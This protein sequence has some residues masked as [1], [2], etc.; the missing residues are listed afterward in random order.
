MGSGKSIQAS[1]VIDKVREYCDTSTGEHLAFAYFYFDFNNDDYRDPI[2]MLRSLLVQVGTMN[3]KVEKSLKQRLAVP[4]G[5]K[6]QPSIEL[7][8]SCLRELVQKFGTSYIVLDALDECKDWYE[9]HRMITRILSWGKTLKVLLISRKERDIEE[10]LDFL[11]AEKCS[12]S[13]QGDGVDNDMRTYIQSMWNMEL[14]AWA[15]RLEK[16]PKRR[17]EIEEELVTKA[18]GM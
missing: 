4:W 12:I 17:M 18:D 8:Y 11:Q 13:L 3:P 2:K 10:D 9:L 5:E 6:R 14:R 15:R 16:R 1:R 7:I